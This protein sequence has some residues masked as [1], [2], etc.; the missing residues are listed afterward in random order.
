MVGVE[1][2]KE[3]NPCPECKETFG[4]FLNAYLTSRLETLG[5][6]AENGVNRMFCNNLL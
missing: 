6:D 3:A 4:D 2:G 1:E 5:L